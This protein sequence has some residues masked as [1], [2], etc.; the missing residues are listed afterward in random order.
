MFPVLINWIIFISVCSTNAEDLGLFLKYMFCFNSGGGRCKQGEIFK[1]PYR[2]P[3]FTA[4][5]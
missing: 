1:M 4:L 5:R 3:L 2:Y